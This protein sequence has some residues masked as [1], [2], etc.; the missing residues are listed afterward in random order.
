VTTQTYPASPDLAAPR[1]GDTG[2]TKCTPNTALKESFQDS[3]GE[4]GR[5]TLA[6]TPPLREGK[7]EPRSR[8]IQVRRRGTFSLGMLT[9]PWVSSPMR[10]YLLVELIGGTCSWSR[11]EIGR[12]VGLSAQDVRTNLRRLV[13]R[14]ILVKLGDQMFHTSGVPLAE[15]TKDVLEEQTGSVWCDPGQSARIVSIPDEGYLDLPQGAP[16]TVALGHF[17]PWVLDASDTRCRKFWE[18][19]AVKSRKLA[20]RLKRVDIPAAAITHLMV[21]QIALKLREAGGLPRNTT[22]P[23][24]RLLYYGGSLTRRNLPEEA[25]QKALEAVTLGGDRISD[26]LKE[27]TDGN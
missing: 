18:G 2:G 19:L 5:A 7:T 15:E 9:A 16:A 27:D 20:S 23:V 12:A 17:V 13:K 10:I 26:L 25:V 22:S 24:G 21:R 8:K 3:V 1:G 14:G 4:G 11:S 6:A